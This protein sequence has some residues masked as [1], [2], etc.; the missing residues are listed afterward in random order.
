MWPHTVMWLEKGESPDTRHL[1]MDNVIVT[2]PELSV[3][4]V[5]AVN[6]WNFVTLESNWIE[7]PLQQIVLSQYR[8]WYQK[9]GATAGGKKKEEENY[10]VWLGSAVRQQAARKML[11]DTLTRY[12]G[13]TSSSTSPVMIQKVTHTPPEL[14]D[15]GEYGRRN[16]N[17][18][19]VQPRIRSKRQAQANWTHFQAKGKGNHVTVQKFG[20]LQIKKI[21]LLLDTM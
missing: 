2:W 4:K 17:T 10:N 5:D 21:H 11:S 3:V 13:K 8:N 19:Y 18:S 12:T 20:T 1:I 6:F 16:T 7:L 15:R 14:V 9:W